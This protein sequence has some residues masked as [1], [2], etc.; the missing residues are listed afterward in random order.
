MF[1]SL[2]CL[3]D[4]DDPKVTMFITHQVGLI[5]VGTARTNAKRQTIYIMNKLTNL[6]SSVQ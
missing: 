6:N 1:I 3:V 5:A 4:K 2:W